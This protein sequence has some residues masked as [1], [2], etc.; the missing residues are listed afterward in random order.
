MEGPK[1][2]FFLNYFTL[3]ATQKSDILLAFSGVQA[4]KA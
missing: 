2:L 4:I 3:N 1:G